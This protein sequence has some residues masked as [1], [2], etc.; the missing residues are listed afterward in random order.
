MEAMFG[1]ERVQ[2][3]II[4]FEQLN[5]L[6]RLSCGYCVEGRGH[7]KHVAYASDGQRWVEW[8][9]G[10][11]QISFSQRH[12]LESPSHIEI[13]RLGLEKG[14]IQKVESTMVVVRF[15]NPLFENLL[16]DGI[17]SV[18]H[19]AIPVELPDASQ[20][21]AIMW[22][23]KQIP[24]IPPEDAF[25]IINKEK[26]IIFERRKDSPS[27]GVTLRRTGDGEADWVETWSWNKDG[28]AVN[29]ERIEVN[30]DL[31]PP[32]F[33]DILPP[34]HQVHILNQ[35]W[36]RKSETISDSTRRLFTDPEIQL[37]AFTN[38]LSAF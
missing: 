15:D 14:R 2:P 12:L 11:K 19:L 5:D 27:V 37:R 7:G 3:A 33:S 22:L 4:S 21:K 9:G 38:Q 24:A 32:L 10:Q 25:Q 34:L 28:Q 26:G 6:K 31:K 13:W 35:V 20:E 30:F 36:T 17:G 18:C 23:L 29:L 16:D 1:R 8:V